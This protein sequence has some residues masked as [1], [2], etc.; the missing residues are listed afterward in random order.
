MSLFCVT[1]SMPG[2]TCVFYGEHLSSCNELETCKGCVPRQA[3]QGLLCRGC[4]TRYES[5]LTTAPTTE[6]P[7]SIVDLIVHLR[8]IEKG[9][10]SVDGI[11]TSTVAQPT[12][13][14]SWQEADELWRALVEIAVTYA[15]H[16]HLPYPVWV[17]NFMGFSR[18]ATLDDVARQVRE[19]AAWITVDTPNTIRN[20]TG[21]E[22][23]VLF[24][25]AVQRS[26]HRYPM[27]DRAERKPIRCDHCQQF[28]IWKRPP[29]EY[30][31][32]IDYVCVNPACGRVYEPS[33]AGFDMLL[34]AEEIS[35]E[36]TDVSERIR[37]QVTKLQ[38]K[39]PLIL[40]PSWL[41]DP[42]A[43]GD[44]R[45]TDP[46][47][48]CECHELLLVGRGAPTPVRSVGRPLVLPPSSAAQDPATCPRCWL[49][50]PEGVC[51]E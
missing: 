14:A 4:F 17:P 1:E 43:R 16:T 5:A 9:P 42:C 7:F 31:D 33:R 34:L 24:Y 41:S 26:L 32:D 36:R 6:D 13:P 30:L 48:R 19:L 21:A 35:N 27:Q 37:A 45:C 29:L 39:P 47:C 46:N 25:R 38:A 15:D 50:H 22:L 2:R 8:S 12:T 20:Q 49:I 28:T 40:E 11:R 10:Q 51:D 3:E 44:H 18:T 23:A